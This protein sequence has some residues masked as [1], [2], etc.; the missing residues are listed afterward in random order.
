M[1]GDPSMVPVDRA[2]S[3]GKRPISLHQRILHDIEGNILSGRWPPG[4]RIPSEQA[5]TDTYGCSRMTVNK[6]LTE[7]A[8]AGLVLRR[9]KTGSVVMPQDGQSAILEIYD[10]GEEVRALNLAYRHTVLSRRVRRPTKTEQALSTLPAR[11]RVLAIS[12]MHLAGE[13]PFCLEERIINLSI[14][15]EAETEAFE[16]LAPGQWLL[17]HVPWSAAEHR[18]SAEAASAGAVAALGLQRS[19]PVLVV[20]RQTWRLEETVTRVRLT[21]PGSQH[22]LTARFTPLHGRQSKTNPS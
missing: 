5:L 3:Q 22:A 7:L 8:R 17:E 16:M 11:A 4:H 18:I 21:Y 9:R 1:A 15:P 6:V 10:I 12:V 19:A 20:E 2:G 13:A 14:A